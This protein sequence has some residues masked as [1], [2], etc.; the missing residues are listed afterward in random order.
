MTLAFTLPVAAIVL[1]AIVVASAAFYVANE[2]VRTRVDRLFRRQ[3]PRRWVGTTMAVVVG[4]WAF[5]SL[6]VFGSFVA[7]G[8]IER[9]RAERRAQALAAQEAAEKQ[10]AADEAAHKA[11]ADAL[12][13]EAEQ[14]AANGEFAQARRLAEQVRSDI[15]GHPGTDGVMQQVN[16][17]LRQQLLAALPAK[18]VEVRAS[19][20]A[21]R[22]QEAGVVCDEVKAVVAENSHFQAECQRVV[23][24]LRKSEV[25]G[26]I[27]EARRVVADECDT[28]K[29]IADAW[30]DLRQ[31]GAGDGA[32]PAA[33][34][35]AVALEK[36]RKKSERAFEEGVRQ[37]MMSQRE[38]RADEP[39]DLDAGRGVMFPS[40]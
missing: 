14:A 9:A 39:R 1:G 24:Q 12:V 34:K 16:D 27:Q 13:R 23:A 32:F 35:A 33:K 36:C 28:P 7:S 8:G 29:S 19:A 25:D 38:R 15:P 11:Q 30:S 22:W 3:K 17:G 6:L 21:G 40:L 5:V 4:F 37:V 20:A 10:R 26:W 18:L 2:G 31:V